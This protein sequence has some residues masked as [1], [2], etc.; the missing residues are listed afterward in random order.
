MQQCFSQ[1]LDKT[2]S[3]AETEKHGLAE[4]GH[5]NTA[6]QRRNTKQHGK[7]KD[8]SKLRETMIPNIT[9]LKNVST[10]SRVHEVSDFLEP[11]TKPRNKVSTTS[12]L[13]KQARLFFKTGKSRGRTIG[14]SEDSQLHHGARDKNRSAGKKT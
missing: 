6:W 2:T 1:D 10:D 7:G 13:S 4:A 14:Y 5:K 11:V 3:L 12:I 9:R 8:G